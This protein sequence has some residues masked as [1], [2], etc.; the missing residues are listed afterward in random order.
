[1]IERNHQVKIMQQIYENAEHVYIWLG[2]PVADKSLFGFRLAMKLVVA[3]YLKSSTLRDAFWYGDSGKIALRGQ[4]LRC[5]EG[6]FSIGTR[7]LNPVMSYVFQLT[8]ISFWR[9]F[10]TWNQDDRVRMD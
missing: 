5:L 6:T 3:A 8:I 7:I 2:S 1:M 10:Q 4:L 9:L